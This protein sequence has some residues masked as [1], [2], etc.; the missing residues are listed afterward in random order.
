MC[1]SN[2]NCPNCN[3]FCPTCGKPLNPQIPNN[4]GGPWIVP[5]NPGPYYDPGICPITY[6]P[7][8]NGSPGISGTGP[9]TISGSSSFS[10]NIQTGRESDK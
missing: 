8:P 10:I 5:Y 1:I 3:R 4:T 9:W 2:G 7:Y 6:N